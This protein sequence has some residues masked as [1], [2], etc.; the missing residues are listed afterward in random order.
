M[1]NFVDRSARGAVAARKIKGLAGLP[2]KRASRELVINQQLRIAMGFVA[3][4]GSTLE[5]GPNFCA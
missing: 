3:D 5:V 1:D 2:G 4:S